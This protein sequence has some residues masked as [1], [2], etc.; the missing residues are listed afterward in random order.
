M[1]VIVLILPFSQHFNSFMLLL[2]FYWLIICILYMMTFPLPIM[3]LALSCWLLV[4]CWYLDS[5]L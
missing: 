5:T 4:T 1:S 3:G 2:N